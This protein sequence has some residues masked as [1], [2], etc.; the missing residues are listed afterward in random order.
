[1]PCKTQLSGDTTFTKGIKLQIQ[2]RVAEVL[3]QTIV[4]PE[5]TTPGNPGHAGLPGLL[6]PD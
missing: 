6:I 5:I 1:M 3:A 2:K 4:L